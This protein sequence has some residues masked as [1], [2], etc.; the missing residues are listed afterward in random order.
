MGTGMVVRWPWHRTRSP[1]STGGGPVLPA[2]LTTVVSTARSCVRRTWPAAQRGVRRAWSAVQGRPV[3]WAG[4]LRARPTAW[5]GALRV[6][7]VAENRRLRGR[8]TAW[9]GALRVWPAAS[10]GALRAWSVA[11]RGAL[12][13]CPTAPA[14]WLEERLSRLRTLTRVRGELGMS[15]AEY[16]VGTI[17]ACAFAALLFKV[18]TSPGVRE[19]LTDLVG[20]A[21]KLAG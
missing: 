4:A 1:H 10:A 14:R 17:A 13:A 11:K 18:V 7:S 6:R 21:L 2:R 12:R 20:R 3:A 9:A 15:T 16:A 19:M 8:P 5:A